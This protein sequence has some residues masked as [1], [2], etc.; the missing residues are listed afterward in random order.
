MKSKEFKKNSGNELKGCYWFQ[1]KDNE[2]ISIISEY[3]ER[4]G[5]VLKTYST[6]ESAKWGLST[7]MTLVAFPE[8]VEIPTMTHSKKS[9]YIRGYISVYWPRMYVVKTKRSK[10]YSDLLWFYEKL[11]ERYGV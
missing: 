3:A 9:D 4:K 8:G 11:V 1:F 5:L 6:A 7:E 10:I 2:I